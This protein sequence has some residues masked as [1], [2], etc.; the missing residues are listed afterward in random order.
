M[1]QLSSSDMKR[2]AQLARLTLSEDEENHLATQLSESLDFVQNLQ[3]V[4]TSHVPE[5]FFT[6]DALNVMDEDVVDESVMLTHE[7]ALKNAPS[8]RK[9]YFVVKRIL[10]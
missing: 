7:Q 2:L 5:T 3:S 1:S 10:G 4:D 6:T 8:T 9:G